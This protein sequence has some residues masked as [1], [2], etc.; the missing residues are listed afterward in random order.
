M[1]TERT[2]EGTM[3][4]RESEVLREEVSKERKQ[5]TK[6]KRIMQWV[7][8]KVSGE[9]SRCEREGE[10]SGI[11]SKQC[12]WESLPPE[13]SEEKSNNHTEPLWFCSSLAF[14][15]FP[16]PCITLPPLWE[17]LC[18]TGRCLDVTHLGNKNYYSSKQW[19]I[20]F[21]LAYTKKPWCTQRTVRLS[22]LCCLVKDHHLVTSGRVKRFKG[23]KRKTFYK[24]R[25]WSGDRSRYTAMAPLLR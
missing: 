10:Y 15:C 9:G 17:C 21:T 13:K 1:T 2:C 14:S 3:I 25:A 22:D 11:N 19:I 20:K 12:M 8:E 5:K 18:K 24:E 6:E 23:K 4:W 16:L 7:E